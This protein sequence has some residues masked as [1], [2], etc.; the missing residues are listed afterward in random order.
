MFLAFDLVCL[1]LG[2]LPIRE[3]L[4]FMSSQTFLTAVSKSYVSTGNTCRSV[5]LMPMEEVEIGSSQAIIFQ[6]IL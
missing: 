1:G 4:C 5:S 3:S 2:I 6:T